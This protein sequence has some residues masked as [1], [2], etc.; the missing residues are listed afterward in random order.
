MRKAKVEHVHTVQ[1]AAGVA[2]L[3]PTQK[4]SR[5]RFEKILG[6]AEELLL[7]RGSD[8]F[9]MSDIVKRAGVPFG[10]LYQYFPD[11]TAIIGTLAE[12]YNAIVN[13]SACKGLAAIRGAEDLHPVLS[14][15]TDGYY[16]WY[17]KEPVLAAIWQ[18]TLADRALQD[19]DK[20]DCDYLAGL[21]SEALQ[22][23]VDDDPKEIEAFS[24]LAIT[25]IG[26]AVRYAITLDE[27]EAERALAQFK[28]MLPHRLAAE[29][30]KG[31][32]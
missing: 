7:E 18:A 19:I 8:A 28:R 13:E 11:K 4:R 31:R 9:R 3:A 25:L 16:Q 29:S 2:R 23:F 5:E 6:C 14:G 26:A 32:Q 12:R 30:A 17:R 10:S 24:R 15:L 22:P 1:G 20:Q 27:P 21:L